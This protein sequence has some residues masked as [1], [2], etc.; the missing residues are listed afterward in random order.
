MHVELGERSRNSASFQYAQL[1]VLLNACFVC[2]AKSS[3]LGTLMVVVQS[4][5]EACARCCVDLSSSN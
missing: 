1:F 3:G 4:S 5:L 2:V